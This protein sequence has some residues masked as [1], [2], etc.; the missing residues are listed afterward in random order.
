[1]NDVQLKISSDFKFTAQ[2]L[3]IKSIRDFDI[4]KNH[5]Q[6]NSLILNFATSISS[7]DLI[8]F[9]QNVGAFYLDSCIDPWNYTHGLINTSE[10]TNYHMRE[11]VLKIHKSNILQK[12]THPEKNFPTAIFAHGANPGFVSLLVKQALIEMSKEFLHHHPNPVNRKEWTALAKSLGVRVIQISERDS[13]KS[14]K[15]L[16]P[17]VFANT[18]SVEALI[19]EAL[20]PAELGWGSHE[21]EGPHATIVRH[22]EIGCKAAVY[23]PILGARCDVKTW[24]PS[25]GTFSGH[26][27]SHNEAISL[28]DYFSDTSN[29]NVNYRPTVYYAYR[30]CEEAE[31]MLKLIKCV[32]R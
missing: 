16:A 1:M 23:Y 2:K 12:Q 21:E 19:A 5:I 27:I 24:T 29:E 25:F 17:E 20:Q 32:F 28:A 15:K 26:L 18:W 31:K 8:K 13:Q 10:N 14:S 4:L 22:H 30:P 11:E 3:H 6:K 9:T 7:R